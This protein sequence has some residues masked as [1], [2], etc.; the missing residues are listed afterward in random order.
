[1]TCF[2]FCTCPS[3]L[4]TCRMPTGCL[5]VCEIVVCRPLGASH[6]PPLHL[7]QEPQL[8]DEGCSVTNSLLEG[9]VTVGPGSVI[10]HCH[11]KV[12]ALTGVG[13][14]VGFAPLKAGPRKAMMAKSEYNKGIK[15]K[16]RSREMCKTS[17]SQVSQ[18][19]GE[20]PR[21]GVFPSQGI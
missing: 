12:H 1:M 4:Q 16:S 20:M 7:L 14:G 6:L 19:P 21:T 11:L 13:Q 3:C 9:A 15:K 10:Q 5:T 18:I 17:G 8:L 2:V